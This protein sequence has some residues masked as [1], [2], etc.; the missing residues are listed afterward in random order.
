MAEELNEDPQ[1]EIVV[2]VPM[3]LP[4]EMRH[5]LFMRVTQAVRRWEPVERDGWEADW[6][7]CP[8]R[9]RLSY[10]DTQLLLWL[11]AEAVWTS[12]N[13]LEVGDRLGWRLVE[14]EA[15]IGRLRREVEFEANGLETG[16]EYLGF[17]EPV[18][19]CACSINAE[20]L[21]LTRWSVPQCAVHPEGQGGDAA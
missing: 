17:D 15:E 10:R 5:D 9:D 16:A 14:A 21:D 4:V 11:H 19:V 12:E 3:R 8:E 6:F 1:W 2:R 13:R 18:R 7:G 20:A